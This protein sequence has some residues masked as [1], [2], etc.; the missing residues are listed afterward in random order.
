MQCIY[1]LLYGTY[2]SVLLVRKIVIALGLFISP[3]DGGIGAT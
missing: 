2:K 1:G 3:H